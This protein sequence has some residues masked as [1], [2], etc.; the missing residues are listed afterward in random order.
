MVIVMRIIASLDIR[1]WLPPEVNT[2][3]PRQLDLK[4]A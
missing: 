3:G 4:D 2:A 1:S